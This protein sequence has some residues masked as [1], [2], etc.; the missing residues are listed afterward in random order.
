MSLGLLIRLMI[1]H[2]FTHCTVLYILYQLGVAGLAAIQTA[3]K[4]MIFC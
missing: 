2:S 1:G 4:M 3:K